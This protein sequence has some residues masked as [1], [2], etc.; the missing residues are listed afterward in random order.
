[1]VRATRERLGLRA[2]LKEFL[3]VLHCTSNYPAAVDDVNL[4]AMQTIA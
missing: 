1:M 3:T 2:Q 4:R